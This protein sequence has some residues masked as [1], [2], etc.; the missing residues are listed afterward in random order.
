MNFTKASIIL[1][2]DE[3][4]KY[5]VL[6]TSLDINLAMH[7]VSAADSTGNLRVI[8]LRKDLPL[9]DIKDF[10]EAPRGNS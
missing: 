4:N 8:P 1:E 6:T 5:A 2:T 3:G 10:V 7:L 9:V